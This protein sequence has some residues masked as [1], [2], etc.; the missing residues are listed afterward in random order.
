MHIGGLPMNPMNLKKKMKKI[1]KKMRLRDRMMKESGICE[2]CGLPIKTP[3]QASIDHI[4]PVS[5]G[6][7][8]HSPANM[9]LAHKRCN[10]RKGN[11]IMA[12]FE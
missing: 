7:D 9:Q 10:R 6:G 2:L 5:K 4:V 12:S 1:L 8:K 11:K 3:S